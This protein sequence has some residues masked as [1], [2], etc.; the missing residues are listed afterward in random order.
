IFRFAKVVRKRGRLDAHI[1]DTAAGHAQCEAALR[2]RRASRT[3][4]AQ[5]AERAMRRQQRQALR[6]N[7]NLDAF[8]VYRHSRAER[9]DCSG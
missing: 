9:G 2:R 8:L 5:P 3:E 7:G 4:A 1:R 6:E